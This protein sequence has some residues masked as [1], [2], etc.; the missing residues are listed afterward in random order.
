MKIRTSFLLFLLF[1]GNCFLPIFAQNPA[2]DV[3][4]YT[5][6]IDLNDDNDTIYGKADI[7]YEFLKTSDA[8]RF[9]LV[10]T[11]A[12]GKGMKVDSILSDGKKLQFQ[13]K[14]ADSSDYSCARLFRSNYLLPRNSERRP[15]H[16][17][18]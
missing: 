18:E 2:I 10:E 5:F 17:P 14:A 4:K 8:V 9:D 12:S 16:K 15:H 1:T 3:K 13:Q 11:D 7:D 6:S